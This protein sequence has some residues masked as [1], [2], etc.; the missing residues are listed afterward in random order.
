MYLLKPAVFN[1]CPKVEFV[2]IKILI[3]NFSDFEEQY[4]DH[5]AKEYG[6]YRI[7]HIK[8]AVERFIS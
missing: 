4:D 3:D 6:T 1:D 2:R 8:D 7:I 5:Y